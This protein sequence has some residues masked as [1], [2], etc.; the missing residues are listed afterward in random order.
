MPF[1]TFRP[2]IRT[3]AHALF[4]SRVCFLCYATRALGMWAV[5]EK[6]YTAKR[7]ENDGLLL[8]QIVFICNCL[9]S[10]LSSVEFVRTSHNYT[11]PAYMRVPQLTSFPPLFSCKRGLPVK[12]FVEQCLSFMCTCRAR[13]YQ[14]RFISGARRRAMIALN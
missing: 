7:G 1:P 14:A 4:F 12:K 6:K 2:L 8:L 5:C 11:R 13:V 9:K 3:R 10:C